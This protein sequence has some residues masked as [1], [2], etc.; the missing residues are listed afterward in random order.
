[1]AGELPSD[2][3]YFAITSGGLTLDALPR[4]ILKPPRWQDNHAC[5]VP[6]IFARHYPSPELASCRG[7]DVFSAR[8]SW[9]DRLYEPQL[10]VKMG[11]VQLLSTWPGS[12]NRR[13]PGH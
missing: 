10:H 5:R 7:F 3:D 1:M 11:E 8:R 9:M 12:M 13:A 2:Y 6:R 4:S